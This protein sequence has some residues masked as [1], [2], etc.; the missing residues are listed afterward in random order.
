MQKPK[1]YV[2]D[3]LDMDQY[4]EIVP[5]PGSVLIVHG[6]RDNIVH[7]DYA[8]CACDAYSK[9]ADSEAQVQLMMIEGGDHGFSKKHDT[10]VIEKLDDF[11]RSEI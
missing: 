3:V 10:L 6:T 11:L 8:R 7:P 9:R 4:V 2:I 5:Y 1:C